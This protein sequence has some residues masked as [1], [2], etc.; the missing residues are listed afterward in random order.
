MGF[1]IKNAKRIRYINKHGGYMF[2]L[3]SRLFTSVSSLMTFL[4]SFIV[5][6]A[7]N[8]DTKIY[9][10][11]LVIAYFI[12]RFCFNY[13]SL[14]YDKVTNHVENETDLKFN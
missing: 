12:C 5:L 9:V 11:S 8:L 10:L 1:N 4:I 3:I 2:F 7:I 13:A 6:T 14:S